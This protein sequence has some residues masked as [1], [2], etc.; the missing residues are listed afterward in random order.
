MTSH[1][2]DFLLVKYLLIYGDFINSC[3]MVLSDQQFYG[4]IGKTHLLEIMEV[5]L[6]LFDSCVGM[7]IFLN[8]QKGAILASQ[9]GPSIS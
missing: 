2:Q 4:Q 8:Q 1:A 9:V 6:S 5:S 7:Q 3:Y